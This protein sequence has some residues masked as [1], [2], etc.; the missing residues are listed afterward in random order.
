VHAQ[1]I[2]RTDDA[3][4]LRFGGIVVDEGTQDL[5]SSL[6]DKSEYSRNILI[7]MRDVTLLNS[8]GIGMLLKVRRAIQAQGG[9]M[10]LLDV[11]VNVRQVI[12]FM[13]LGQIL[14]IAN[15]EQEARELLR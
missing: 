15:S 10:I 8:N 1:R 2:P 6:L 13:K 7:S 11:P 12:D 3:I 5:N 14:Q 4:L 9:K